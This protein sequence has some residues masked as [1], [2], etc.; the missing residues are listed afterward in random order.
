MAIQQPD[1]AV[2]RRAQRGD[3]RAFALI[4]R[5]Y[6]APIFNYVLRMVGDRALAED[7]TQDV[8]LRVFRGLRGYSR[9]ARFTTWLFQVAKN[10]VIDEM[11]AAERRPRSLVA[12]EDAP[13]LEVVDAPI[14]QSEAIDILLSEVDKLSPDLKEA[15]L[16]RDIAGLSYNEISDTLEVT[17]A[18]VKWRIFKAREEVQQALEEQ[19]VGVSSLGESGSKS[20]GS[21]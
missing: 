11:R 8:F 5:A 12:I 10:R 17:L 2:I 20:A 6:E 9:R 15:L 3:E 21:S 4:M 18:T 16:L 1:M 13:Q 19:G 14:E 7:L